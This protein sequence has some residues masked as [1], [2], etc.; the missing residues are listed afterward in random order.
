MKDILEGIRKPRICKIDGCIKKHKAR[1]FCKTHYKRLMNHG[2]PHIGMGPNGFV[3]DW[4]LEHAI[5][6]GNECLIWPYASSS[7]GYPVIN[8]QKY[9]TRS[10]TRIMCEMAHGLPPSPKHQ[11]AHSCGNGHNGCINPQHLRWATPKENNAD[12]LVHGTRPRGSSRPNAKLN[13][14]SVAAARDAYSRHEKNSI[15]LANELGV[16]QSTIS[17]ILNRR[18]WAHV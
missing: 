16:S 4:L 10:A 2:S 1:G 7:T 17:A 6:D 5:H 12:Q 14:A 11:C 13:E 8:W 3:Q 15:E 18:T 9:K